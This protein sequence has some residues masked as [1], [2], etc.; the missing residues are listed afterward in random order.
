MITVTPMVSVTVPNPDGQIA[1]DDEMADLEPDDIGEGLSETE[2]AA[3]VAGFSTSSLYPVIAAAAATG[4]RRNELLALRWTDLDPGRKTLRIEWALEQTKKFGIRRK[5]PKTKRGWRTIDLD[6]S[7]V[8]VLLAEK[9]KHLRLYAGIPD[10]VDV[11]L[12]LIRLPAGALM[13][14]AIPES[15]EE[16]DLTKPRNPR[17]FSKEFARRAD[18]LGF[19]KTRFHDLRGIHGTALLDANIPIHTVAQRLGDDPAIILRNYT[20]RKR[21]AKADTALADAITALAAGFLKP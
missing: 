4:A 18:L 5:R 20:K 21:T 17:N 10:G 11:N 7:I 3:L 16:F 19:G 14:P 8:A 12:G 6:G 13:F 1:D 15:G 2:L 9:E